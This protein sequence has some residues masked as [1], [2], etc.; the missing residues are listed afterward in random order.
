MIY[1]NENS[2]SINIPR[3]TFTEVVDGYNL[4][5]TSNM[6]D[7][8]V[9]VENGDNISTNSMYYRFVIDNLN[10]MNV[11]EYTYKLTGVLDGDEVVLE[12]G[13]ITYGKYKRMVI[14]NNAFNTNKIQYNG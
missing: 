1:I 12:K 9:L 13:L 10:R 4:I 11:G 2:G 8:V 5:L 7:E 6:S 14:V 3:H